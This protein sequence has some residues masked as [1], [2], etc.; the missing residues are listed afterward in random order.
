MKKLKRSMATLLASA[1]VM[2]TAS[3]AQIQHQLLNL[4]HLHPRLLRLLQLPNRL[5][6]L[7][8]NPRKLAEFLANQSR[9]VV[10]S[11]SSSSIIL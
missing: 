8:M 2:A 1:S 3:F 7:R 4:L 10:L 9:K 5:R 6:Y 11:P